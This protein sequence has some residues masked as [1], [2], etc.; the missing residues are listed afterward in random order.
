MTVMNDPAFY[1]QSQDKIKATQDELSALTETL[2]KAY[3]RWDELEEKQ[4]ATS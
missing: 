2:E 3:S 4:N 1:Q